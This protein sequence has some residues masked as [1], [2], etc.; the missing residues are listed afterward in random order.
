MSA[1][2]EDRVAKR[3]INE[4]EQK[5]KTLQREIRDLK[6]EKKQVGHLRKQAE[7]AVHL[8]A[9]CR[10]ILD[11]VDAEFLDQD[12]TIKQARSLHQCKNIE[13]VEAKQADN[14]VIIEAGARLIIICQNCGSRYSIVNNA[15]VGK[16]KKQQTRPVYC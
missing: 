11:E 13:C 8:E 15:H 7:R 9:E 6:Q 5:L 3:R 16:N 14:C 4:L 2:A 1:T 12:I 10:D